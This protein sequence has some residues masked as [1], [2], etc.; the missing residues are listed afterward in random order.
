MTDRRV[1]QIRYG[2]VKAVAEVEVWI[3]VE[4]EVGQ[5]SGGLAVWGWNLVNW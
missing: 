5:V 1:R 2:D 3:E 4:I